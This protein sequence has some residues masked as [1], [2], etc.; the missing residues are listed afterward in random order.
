MILPK[1]GGG[2]GFAGVALGTLSGSIGSASLGL[3]VNT[4]G[5]NVDQVVTVNGTAIPIK[6]DAG[7]TFAVVAQDVNLN[8]GNLL[9]IK[10][11]FALSSNSFSGTGLTLFVGSGPY[12]NADGS[13]NANAIGLVINQAS[14][15]FHLAPGAG[16]ADG[17][18]ALSATGS[19][20]LVG[21][22]GLNLTFTSVSFLINTTSAPLS[23]TGGTHRS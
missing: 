2:Y 3:E 5:Q 18:Y 15:S 6:I 1:S 8:L 23:P 20:A 7:T 17:L 21:L 10:G 4:T 14:L 9:E 12:D 19:V 22:D 13:P 16:K 11:N